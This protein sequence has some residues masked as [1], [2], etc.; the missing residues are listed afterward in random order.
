MNWREL[1]VK[2]IF[3]LIITFGPFAI[4]IRRDLDHIYSRLGWKVVFELGKQSNSTKFTRWLFVPFMCGSHR[5]VIFTVSS[6]KQTF[7]PP[8]TFCAV[9]WNPNSCESLIQPLK[10]LKKSCIYLWVLLVQ[11]FLHSQSRNLP[12]NI[13]HL[14]LLYI[15]IKFLK[16]S[17]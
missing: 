10:F 7:P 1:S 15:L 13:F 14:Y 2:L 6:F 16:N 11:S 5:E 9:I 12:G 8:K 17:F 4:K 3:F